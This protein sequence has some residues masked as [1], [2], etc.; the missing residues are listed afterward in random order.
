MK[1]LRLKAETTVGTETTR[2]V[3]D[4]S[5][6]LMGPKRPVTDGWGAL[7]RETVCARNDLFVARFARLEPE[8][9]KNFGKP[10]YPE[11]RYRRLNL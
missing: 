7:V 3:N 4:R 1:G 2:W 8:L 6:R 10:C 11:T 5:K 9:E